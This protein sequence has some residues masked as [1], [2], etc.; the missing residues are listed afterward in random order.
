MIAFPNI[1]LSGSDVIVCGLA[2]ILAAALAYLTGAV[3][4]ILPKMRTG[5]AR[6]IIVRLSHR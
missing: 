5:L 6:K 1:P 4:S 2:I 3:T